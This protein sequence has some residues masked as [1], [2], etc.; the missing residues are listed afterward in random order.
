MS[1]L[2]FCG[3]NEI[4]SEHDNFE[5]ECKLVKSSERNED[6]QGLVR[7]RIWIWGGVS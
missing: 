7:K 6:W 1:R 5:N 3:E 4:K 2:F